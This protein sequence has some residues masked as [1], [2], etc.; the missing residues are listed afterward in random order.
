MPCCYLFIVAWLWSWLFSCVYLNAI[1]VAGEQGGNDAIW[2]CMG[3]KQRLGLCMVYLAN[4]AKRHGGEPAGDPTR[5]WGRRYYRPD[6]GGAK[7]RTR[8]NYL[9]DRRFTYS[10]QCSCGHPA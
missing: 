2:D 9:P 8:E 10:T 4:L 5:L 7:R 6:F 3:Y 1:P